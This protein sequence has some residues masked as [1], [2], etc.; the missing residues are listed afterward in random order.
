MRISRIVVDDEGSSISKEMGE[1]TKMDIVEKVKRGKSYA[2]IIIDEDNSVSGFTAY[3]SK[4]DMAI[5]LNCL[6]RVEEEI[7]EDLNEI[8]G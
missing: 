5:I 2:M 8:P 4:L 3:S 6:F 1:K 7:R